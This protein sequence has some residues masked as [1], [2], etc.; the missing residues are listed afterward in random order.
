MLLREEGGGIFAD[1]QGQRK[2]FKE[3]T[4]KL[5]PGI[6]KSI[7]LGRYETGKPRPKFDVTYHPATDPELIGSKLDVIEE[8]S[9]YCYLAYHFH[10]FGP[11]EC[12]VTVRRNGSDAEAL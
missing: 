3:A 8:G 6:G 12:E 5:G 9:K 2:H 10:N 7:P 11:R 1:G 4:L